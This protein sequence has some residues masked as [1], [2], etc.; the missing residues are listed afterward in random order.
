MLYFHD[1]HL[2]GDDRVVDEE[3]E[4]DDQRAKRDPVQVE[5]HGIHDHEHDGEDEWNGQR[6][7]DAGAPAKRKEADEQ[8]DRQCLNK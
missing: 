2:D 1:H 7:D 3:A 8:H 6:D 4:R 5:A